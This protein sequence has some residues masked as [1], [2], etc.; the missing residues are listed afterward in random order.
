MTWGHGARRK[1]QS[2]NRCVFIKKYHPDGTFY[3]KKC[4]IAFRGDRWHDLYCSKTYAGRAMSEILRLILAVATTELMEIGCLNVKTA[5]LYGN[6]PGFLYGN[7]IEI[8]ILCDSDYGN[9][10]LKL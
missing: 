3:E 9:S 1:Y 5:F 10:I 4:R 2:T 6:L 7:K 8:Y